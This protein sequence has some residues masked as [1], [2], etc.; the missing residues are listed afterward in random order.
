MT[1]TANDLRRLTE[2]FMRTER[3]IRQGG[4]A[5]AIE[6]QHAKGRLTARERIVRLVD[7]EASP[8][9]KP[10]DFDPH[11]DEIHNFT[12]LGLWCAHGMY[13]EHG[14]A[15]AAGVVTGIGIVH[16]RPHMIIANDATVKAGAFFPMTC[17]K[18]IRAQ[19]IAHTARLPLIY[20]VDSAGVYLP[21]QEDV[22]P[23]TDDFGR[24]FRNN[25]V[26]SAEGIPQ[27]AAIM[28][29]CVA[30]GGYLPVLCDTLLMTEG[31][32]LYLAGP[33]LVKAAIGQQ[34]SDEELGGAEMHASISGT[35]DFREPDDEACLRRVRELVAKYGASASAKPG[36]AGV[37]PTV[38]PAYRDPGDMHAIFTDKPGQQ[39]DVADI[40]ACI[41]DARTVPN[42]DGHESL[43]P[44][45]D[46]Y[47]AEYGQSL[48]C[49]YARI[50][51]YAAGIVANQCKLTTR[52]MPGGKAG[53]SKSTNMPRVIYDDS[54]DKAARFIMDCNQRKIPIVFLHDTTGFMV[55]RDSEQ[56][57]IIRAGAKLVNAMSN[58]VVP[59]IVVIIGGSYGAGNYAMCGR[60]FDQFLAFAWPSAKCAVMGAAQATGTLAM[61]EEKSRE[62]KGETIDPETHKAILDAVR[63]SYNEQQDIRHGAARGWVDRII[64][65]HRTRDELI[66]ALNAA[67][68]WDFS[69]EF[70]TGVLQT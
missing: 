6:R 38:S 13:A 10:R 59:K 15:P 67:T 31:S 29:Y 21:M 8:E 50:G 52:T 35:I 18:I 55:G 24:I 19:T 4:G 2:E 53:P 41:A 45:F 61:I 1:A 63:A 42:A 64:E 7:A 48:V 34:V 60:A 51:G 43:A 37:P 9:R 39:Y 49:G 56:A 12:E 33:A 3:E 17:K 5:K 20:L 25:A 44:D 58:C 27:I 23:D 32:G 62:R 36:G 28:G 22:F 66:A 65:P 69:R 70:R 40:I 54:A 26:I 16:G 46:E 11:R 57:G 47:K 68:N 30:G 14:G